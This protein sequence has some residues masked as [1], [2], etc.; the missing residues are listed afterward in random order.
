MA[1]FFASIRSSR[2]SGAL[3]RIRGHCSSKTRARR[4]SS[5]LSVEL[6]TAFGI[7]GRSW[8]DDDEAAGQVIGDSHD[9]SGIVELV[10]I[11]RRREDGY[12][13]SVGEELVAILHDLVCPGQQVQIEALQ[14]VP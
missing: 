10:A 11:F 13:A 1:Y 3:C 7:L 5:S 12:A 4:I 14:K 9:G 2:S 8:P 6:Y